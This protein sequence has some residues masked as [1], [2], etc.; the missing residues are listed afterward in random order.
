VHVLQGDLA[1]PS[2]PMNCSSQYQ[3]RL[4]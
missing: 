3:Y 1:N 4:A 2:T